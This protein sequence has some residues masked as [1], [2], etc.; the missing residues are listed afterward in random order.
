M[1]RPGDRTRAQAL[2]QLLRQFSND[3]QE[4][5]GIRSDAALQTLVAQL[6]ESIR[7]VD[8][9]RTIASQAI[10]PDRANPSK[11]I[12][13]PIRAAIFNWANRNFD[14]AFWLVFLA[15]HF[16]KHS[17]DKWE[18]A[19]AVYGRLGGQPHWNWANISADL[20]SFRLWLDASQSELRT[21]RFGNHRKY[22][23]KKADSKNGLAAVIE[24]YTDLI[25][26]PRTHKEFFDQILK[27]T[28]D[29]VAA[30]EKCN[31]ALCGVLRL[32]R[33]GRFD[34]LCM[35]GNL[36]FMMV[37]PGSTFLRNSTG[38]FSGAQLLL[39]GGATPK[40]SVDDAEE[41]LIRLGKFLAVGQ[42]ELED[43]LCNW[44]KSPVKFVPF[45]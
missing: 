25:G 33:L 15:T 1:I 5:R 9:I 24:S 11:P 30:F 37:T 27:G 8:F 2:S 42:Q 45:R 10:D 44:Q 35:L 29:P 36:G 17:T 7:R 12:F 41:S 28:N 23:S 40:I 43:S 39:K 20:P 38:P 31:E 14:E 26:P 13:D 19:R 32:G 16:G 21:L 6:I 22:E 34:H 18:L 3:V 4:L